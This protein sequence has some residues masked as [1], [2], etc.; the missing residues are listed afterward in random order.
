MKKVAIQGYKGCFHEQAARDFYGPERL[1]VVECDSFDGLFQA[2]DAGVA[3]AAVMAIEN[4]LSGGLIH[5]FEPAE[6]DG[7]SGTVADGHP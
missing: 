1:E 5:N 3:D 4:T 6:P 2:V 7:P